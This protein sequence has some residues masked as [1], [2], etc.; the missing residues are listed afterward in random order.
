MELILTWV[1]SNIEVILMGLSGS[2]VAALISE[3]PYKERLIGW[4]VG[5][6]LCLSLSDV[7]ANVL[8]GG[9]WVGV[10]GFVYG[11][12]GITLAKMIL[13]AIEKKGKSELE[14]K[15]GVKLNDD[16]DK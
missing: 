6:I 16:S 10:F 1:K 3:K 14:S 13:T 11:M 7:T 2:T 5:F 8:T 15:T 4:V 12:G 9:K